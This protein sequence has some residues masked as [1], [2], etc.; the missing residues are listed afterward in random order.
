MTTVWNLSKIYKNGE[1]PLLFSKDYDDKDID[2]DMKYRLS[3]TDG[4]F[5]LSVGDDGIFNKA[6]SGTKFKYKYLKVNDELIGILYN[7]NEIIVNSISSVINT[8]TDFNSEGLIAVTVDLYYN[9]DNKAYPVNYN[10]FHYYNNG[11]KKDLLVQDKGK[12]IIT[13]YDNVL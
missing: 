9:I 5:I 11:Y 4:L 2:K 3:Q 13:T 1:N 8:F 10:I 7:P 12:V 6:V